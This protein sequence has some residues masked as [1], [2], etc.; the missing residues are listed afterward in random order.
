MRGTYSG[1]DEMEGVTL[2]DGD[3]EHSAPGQTIA[4]W[5]NSQVVLSAESN[6]P[7]AT[8]TDET[9]QVSRQRP[10]KEEAPK[11]IMNIVSTRLVCHLDRS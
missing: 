5:L 9:S 10:W 11:N 3:G 2:G 8:V 6:I 4:F 7:K 1:G